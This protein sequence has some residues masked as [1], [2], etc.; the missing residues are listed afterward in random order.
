MMKRIM[1]G[2]MAISA[3]F[4]LNAC[5]ATCEDACA[6]QVEVCATELGDQ[7]DAVK[8][9]CEAG[10]KLAEEDETK[11]ACTNQQEVIDCVADAADCAAATACGD[12]CTPRT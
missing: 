2:L 8:T 12:K 1:T 6:N 11:S 3:A 10:C 7:K 5:G 9:L 4:V